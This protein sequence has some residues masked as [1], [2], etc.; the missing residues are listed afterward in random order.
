MNDYSTSSS[1]L[2][3]PLPSQSINLS[4]RPF[5]YS[6]P[7]DSSE[8][9]KFEDNSTLN[10]RMINGISSTMNSTNGISYSGPS[11][12]NSNLNSNPIE[13]CSSTTLREPTDNDHPHPHPHP[14]RHRHSFDSKK[15]SF[16]T[17]SKDFDRPVSV[18]TLSSDDEEQDQHYHQQLNKF[19]RIGKLKTKEKLA[20]SFSSSF[21]KSSLRQNSTENDST[22]DYH[23]LNSIDKSSLTSKSNIKRERIS[24]DHRIQ[25]SL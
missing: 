1:H 18:I 8:Q 17:K 19:D 11:Y 7:F 4:R 16:K 24:I 22:S 20:F 2:P 6:H 9:L 14:H 21:R 23:L 12:S 25:V 13:Q 5:D 3:V 15:N 10:C